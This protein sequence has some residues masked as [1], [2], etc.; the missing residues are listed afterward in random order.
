VIMGITL[1]THL[2][3]ERDVAVKQGQ[4]VTLAG[5]Q[6]HFDSIRAVKG[7]NYDATLATFSVRQNG[8]LVGML[9]PEKRIYVAQNSPITEAAI[10]GNLI[11]DLYVA[12]GD[13]LDIHDMNGA[14]AVRVYYKPFV[15]WLWVGAL[16]M[17]LG[18][19]LAMSDQRYRLAK[20]SRLDA[21]RAGETR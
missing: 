10:D 4:T 20:R 8:H 9:Y 15:R 1:T 2:S 16:C 18:G 12:L 7:S 21:N 3:I 11:R 6:F 13:P 14:W 17:A 19:I 5:Y